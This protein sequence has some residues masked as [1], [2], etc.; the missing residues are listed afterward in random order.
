MVDKLL[1]LD[2][3]TLYRITVPKQMIIIIEKC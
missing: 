3:N 1:V 2:R